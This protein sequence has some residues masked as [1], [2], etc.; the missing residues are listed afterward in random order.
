MP[1]QYLGVLLHTMAISGLFRVRTELHQ[2]RI[3]PLLAPHPVKIYGQS[4]GQGDFGRLSSPPGGERAFTST[5][6]R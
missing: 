5:A 2:L 4:P 3:V 1:N 6:L